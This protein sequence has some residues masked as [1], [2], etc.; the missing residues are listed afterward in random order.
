[1]RK[2]R[3]YEKTRKEVVARLIALKKALELYEKE[4][5]ES[6]I[7]ADKISDIYESINI[8]EHA[9]RIADYYHNLQK[10]SKAIDILEDALD[11]AFYDPHI[12]VIL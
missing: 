2:Y 3:S 8:L 7:Y 1:M 9:I 4:P 5:D 10:Y 6:Y 12:H 11:K